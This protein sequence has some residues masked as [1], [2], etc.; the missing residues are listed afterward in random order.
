MRMRMTVGGVA[1]VL[2]LWGPWAG[3]AQ[4][5]AQG[6]AGRWPVQPGSP[7][8]RVV[9]PFMEGWYAN[10]DGTF[11]ISL[12]V[13]NAN[14]ETIR[15]PLGPDNFIEPAQFD[16]MQPTVFTPGSPAMFVSS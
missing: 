15:I 4:L 3:P 14:Q 10:E 9:A 13:L 11:S 2:L 1:L 16:G 7:G 12:G 6:P 5:E 8:N